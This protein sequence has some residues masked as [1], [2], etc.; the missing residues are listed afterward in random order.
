MRAAADGT[1]V[2]TRD[3]GDAGEAPPD[4]GTMVI[5]E[6]DADADADL[7]LQTMKREA[8]NIFHS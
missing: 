4:L 5:N 7:D 1:L 6:P 2:P 8:P 3:A